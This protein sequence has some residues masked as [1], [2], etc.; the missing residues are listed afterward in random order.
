VQICNH[1]LLTYPPDGYDSLFL[2]QWSTPDERLVTECGKMQFL[3]R[4]F[5]KFARTGHRVLLFSTMTKVLDLM[6]IYLR[7][8]TVDGARRRQRLSHVAERSLR[9]AIVWSFDVCARDLELQGALTRND[10]VALPTA[11]A[12]VSSTT[13]HCLRPSTCRS[14][15]AAVD[16]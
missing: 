12:L 4:L 3:D 11:L 8:R 2:R 6:E 16:G 15:D 7:W 10:L 14:A 5:L 1:P 13:L 9:F